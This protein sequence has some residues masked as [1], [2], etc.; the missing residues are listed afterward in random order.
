MVDI[1]EGST[2]VAL[3]STAAEGE[4]MVLHISGTGDGL[5][6]IGIKSLVVIFQ[7]IL[8]RCSN[9]FGGIEHLHTLVHRLNAIVALVRNLE[10]L[11]RSLLG[12]HLD[13]TRST[14]G[15]IESGFAGIFQHGKAFDISRIDSSK[16]CHIRCNAI[17]DNQR[18]VD[19]HDGSGTTNSHRV[20]HGNTVETIGSNVHTCRLS[21]QGIKGI[22]E[23]ALLQQF[24]LHYAHRTG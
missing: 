3:Q 12:L 6:E 18:V 16:R 19:A 7:P 2:I 17:D 23:H 5:A 22:I 11:A 21:A 13:N 4:I 1:A 8:L 15:T 20:Q 9:V 24:R 10:S 14:T